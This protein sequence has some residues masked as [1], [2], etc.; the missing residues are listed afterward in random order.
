[1]VSN[2]PL[3]DRE[4]AVEGVLGADGSTTLRVDGEVAG[5]GATRGPLSIYPA[6]L[7]EAGCYTHTKYPAIGEYAEQDRFPGQLSGITVRFGE[8]GSV[9][10]A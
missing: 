5:R 8:E 2:D 6:G 10:E 4:V 3:P 7:L 9:H 1:M